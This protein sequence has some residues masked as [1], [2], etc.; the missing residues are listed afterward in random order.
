MKNTN[1]K[2]FRNS[3]LLV[4]IL[5]INF[6]CEREMSDDA[7]LATYPKT[8]EIFIEDVVGMG[9]DFY[10]PYGPDASNPVGSL[11][12]AWSVDRQV[13][14]NSNASM[15]FD[16][17][18]SNNPQGNYAG[19]IFRTEGAGRN[20]T[21]Y[22][23][24]TF[25]VKASQG[26]T[27]GEFGFGEDFFPN[28]YI[29]TIKNVSVGTNWTKVII[30][31]PDASKLVKE[32]GMFRYSAGTSGTNGFGYTFWI[33]DLKFEKLG[34]ILPLQASI[35]NGNNVTRSTFV[36]VTSSI[37]G[38]LETFNMPNGSNQS[39][40]ISL[41]F[42]NF[43][44]SNPSVAT[45]NDAGVVTPIAAGTATITATFNGQ[46]AT[47]SLIINCLGAYVN[48]PIPTLS[49]SNVISVFSNAYSNVPVDYF[50]GYWGGSQTLSDDF[51][52][53]GDNVL[54]YYNFLYF[55][56]AFSNPF[57]NATT[58]NYIHLDIHVPASNT[59]TS[60]SMRIR[61]RDFGANG[62]D[63]QGGVDDTDKTMVLNNANL[64]SNSWNSIEIPMN[65]A[66]KSKLGLIIF[67][68]GTNLSKFFIDNIYFHN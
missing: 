19:A 40:S 44:S 1:F 38:A 13:G 31:I 10:F 18:N 5:L 43:T 25:Y 37:T 50:N 58:M 56:I 59:S 62:L 21:G 65:I 67:D 30:P 14:Y 57:I 29:T 15:R 49:P 54:S 3:L 9:T 48:A 8:A 2:L 24:L 16:V 63:N 51:I 68:Q 41:A 4:L 46:P 22:D 53:N 34:T 45:V 60:K 6:S 23:A 47:G 12:T 66:N 64:V 32:R 61:I 39:V 55:G 28:K 27:I 11:F 26:V 33:D 20:L 36:G 42:L 35:M 17:P 52:A 7:T